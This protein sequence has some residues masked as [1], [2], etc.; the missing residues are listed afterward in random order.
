MAY[1]DADPLRQV[2]DPAFDATMDKLVEIARRL[3]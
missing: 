3:E 2:V 1:Y